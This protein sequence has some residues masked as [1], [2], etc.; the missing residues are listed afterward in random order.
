MAA[1]IDAKANSE[2]G[3]IADAIQQLQDEG[4]TLA[5]KLDA[6]S[7]A[8]LEQIAA[9]ARDLEK[10]LSERLSSIANASVASEPAFD[11]NRLGLQAAEYV[12]YKPILFRQGRE[13][14]YY[15][16]LVRLSVSTAPIVAEVKAARATLIKSIAIVAAIALAIGVAGSFALS[17]LIIRPLMKVVEGIKHIRDTPDKKN[18]ADFTIDIK[19]KDELSMLAGTINEMT[20]GLV[21]AA[22]EAEFLTV[23]KGVQKMFIPLIQ[24][25]L[26]EKL[27][28]G[29]ED[30]TVAHAS[31]ATTKA[32]RA[33]PATTSTTGRSTAGTG[34]SSSATCRARA[35]P[36][37]SSWSASPP[38]SPRASRAGRYSQGRH[39]TW[40][41]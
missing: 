35:S 34:P 14:V 19:R 26:G 15:R 39:H 25:E 36:R 17:G 27:T 3:T 1:E 5:A 12:F 18:L 41:R 33:C 32:P 7:Q 24:N 10:T 4:R 22:A 23:G 9:S 29:S 20:A 31:T 38:Y 40:T 13:T 2:V 30:D 11:P 37:P 21:H 16:G 6:Q 28:T 8:R